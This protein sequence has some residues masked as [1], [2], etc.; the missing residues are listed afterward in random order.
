MVCVWLGSGLPNLLGDAAIEA[1][2]V[3][4][5]GFRVCVSKEDAEPDCDI[6]VFVFF[7]SVSRL[8]FRLAGL[9]SGAASGSW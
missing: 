1:G 7:G 3:K 5:G 2:M 8:A 4:F 9:V 6:I